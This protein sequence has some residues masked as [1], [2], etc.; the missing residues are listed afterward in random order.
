M[1]KMLK[2]LALA[3]LGLALAAAFQP[4]TLWDDGLRNGLAAQI[5]RSTGLAMTGGRTVFS[6]LPRPRLK[7]EDVTIG[8]FV[9]GMRIEAQSLKGDIALTSLLAGHLVFQHAEF[10]APKI[11][12]DADK[13]LPAGPGGL[14]AVIHARFPPSQIAGLGS[15]S[16][17]GGQ[18]RL[19]SA[20]VGRDIV[21]DDMSLDIDWPMASAP[22][23]AAGQ[24]QWQGQHVTFGA[25]ISQPA[26]VLQGGTSI[27]DFHAGNPDGILGMRG[28]LT[29]GA[30]AVSLTGLNLGVG[31]AEFE[32]ALVLRDAEGTGTL[33]GTLATNVLNLAPLVARLPRVLTA[34]RQ[35]SQQPFAALPALAFD[36]DLRLSA[37][38]VDLGTMKLA[39]VALS[40]LARNNRIEIDLADAKIFGGALKGRAGLSLPPGAADMKVSGTATGIDL[41]QFCAAIACQHGVS[42]QLA[43]ALSAQA[44]GHSASDMAA[45]LQGNLQ[46]SASQGDFAGRDFEQALRRMGKRPQDA[47][48]GL[49]SGTT[50]FDSASASVSVLQGKAVL[51][52]GQVAGPAT[53]LQL[54]GE[55]DIAG[56]SLALK[57][58]AGQTGATGNGPLLQFDLRG[59]WDKPI[60]ALDAPVSAPD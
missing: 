52:D 55:M 51:A 4:W 18:A 12:V 1:K 47:P 25:W 21:I 23:V 7:I 29:F 50:A 60:L 59:G 45:T 46:A 37:A 36:A 54:A 16:L 39:D 11:V 43:L 53:W 40:I 27:V 34:D 5:Q 6:L 30:H 49:R 26:H 14:A 10:L 57:G 31:G 3:L 38:S 28:D 24:G 9:N 42:G 44:T 56:R 35:W 32:G 22:L 8:D 19:T 13:F 33:T 17:T 58:V 20:R 48:A 41:A 15:L 2:W